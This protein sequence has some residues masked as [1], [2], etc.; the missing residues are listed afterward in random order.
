MNKHFWNWA[1]DE[2]NPEERTL[3]LEGPIAEESWYGDEVTPAAFREE[4]FSADGPIVISVNS[5]GGDTIAASQIYTMLRNHKGKVTAWD[6]YNAAT[7][8]YKSAT[9]DQPM[10]LSQNLAMVDFLNTHVL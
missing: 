8:M 4:L 5:P 7:D 2:T 10:I 3:L 1:R 6:F 9:L